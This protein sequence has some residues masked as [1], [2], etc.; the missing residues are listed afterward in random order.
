MVDFDEGVGEEFSAGSADIPPS[1]FDPGS[2]AGSSPIPGRHTGPT[3][4]HGV[5]DPTLASNTLMCSATGLARCSDSTTIQ[6]WP[7]QAAHGFSGGIQP[8]NM[9]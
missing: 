5:T 2:E 8:V 1:P 9:I 4:G 6:T 3:V 7:R